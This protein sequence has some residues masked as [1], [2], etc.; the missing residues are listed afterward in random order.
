MY[1]VACPGT[2]GGQ[3]RAVNVAG[4]A[5]QMNYA[6]LEETRDALLAELEGGCDEY[7][8]ITS[9]R[10]QATRPFG[11]RTA[12][13]QRLSIG[14]LV[15]APGE[16]QLALGHRPGSK[17][18]R[19]VAGLKERIEQRLGEA[20]RV[21]ETADDVQFPDAAALANPPRFEALWERDRPVHL[22]Q[23]VAHARGGAGSIGGFVEDADDGEICFISCSHVIGL[24]G[25][26]DIDRPYTEN[27]IYQPAK[28]GPVGSYRVTDSI[29]YLKDVMALD[30][31]RALTSDSAVARIHPTKAAGVAN[32][33]PNT[34]YKFKFAGRDVKPLPSEEK[35]VAG[36][37]IYKI[38]CSTGMT[39]GTIDLWEE[40]NVP[41]GGSDD[42]TYTFDNCISVRWNRDDT[43]RQV[44][45]SLAGDSGGLCFAEVDDELLAVGLVFGTGSFKEDGALVRVTYVSPLSDILSEFNLEWIE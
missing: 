40:K 24:G 21:V 43:G 2:I 4:K 37:R 15:T 29:A 39:Q 12:P 1:T 33:I 8:F 11:D 22:G 10:F 13:S 17:T 34:R 28:I 18:R 6:Q 27:R 19:F 42:G 32:R 35:L 31:D 20:V 36:T 44:P 23:A 30:F 16:F 38:G 5:G 25:K 9:A 3:L 14:Y 26:A 45:F 7:E 41:I